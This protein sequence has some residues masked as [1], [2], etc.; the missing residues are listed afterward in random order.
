MKIFVP[1]F[2]K[3]CP[4]PKTEGDILRTEGK[5]LMIDEA[6]DVKTFQKKMKNVKNVKTWQKI[7]KTFKTLIKTL[8]LI[9]ST[10]CLK[11]NAVIAVQ[12]ELKKKINK[13]LIFHLSFFLF[14]CATNVGE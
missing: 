5:S 4:R 11:P 1:K 10:S 13:F 8:A 14:C 3:C 6:I 2:V 9:C 7:K 12:L